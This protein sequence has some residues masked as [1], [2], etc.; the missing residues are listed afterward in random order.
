MENSACR[1]TE[2]DKPQGEDED[3]SNIYTNIY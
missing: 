2:G 3:L 1:S